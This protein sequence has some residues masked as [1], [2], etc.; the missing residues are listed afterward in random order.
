MI[1]I[2]LNAFPFLNSL[3]WQGENP[4]IEPLTTAEILSLYERNWRLRGVVA[5]LSADET[6]WIQTYGKL[7]NSWL[8]NEL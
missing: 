5:N 2:D 8:I 6:T 4:S 3:C 1:T 7:H